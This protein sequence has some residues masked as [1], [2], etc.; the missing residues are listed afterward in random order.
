MSLRFKIALGVLAATVILAAALLVLG[1]EA[2]DK[3]DEAAQRQRAI[4]GAG[5]GVIRRMDSPEAPHYPAS[6]QR[7][8]RS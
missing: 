7:R 5:A 1:F 8:G 4:L 2:K 3:R 6:D